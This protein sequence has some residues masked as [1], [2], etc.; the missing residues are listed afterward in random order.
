MIYKVNERKK[1]IVQLVSIVIY[2]GERRSTR[3]AFC[4]SIL[5]MQQRKTLLPYARYQ[6]NSLAEEFKTHR[7]VWYYSQLY[8]VAFI[9]AAG[10][11]HGCRLFRAVFISFLPLPRTLYLSPAS[12]V[13]VVLAS[14]ILFRS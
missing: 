13:F 10:G 14:F 12:S 7:T 11:K 6:A 1:T 3:R 8:G 4:R 5:Q 2:T 9:S